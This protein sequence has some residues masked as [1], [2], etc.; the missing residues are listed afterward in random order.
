METPGVSLFPAS[1]ARVCTR[2]VPGTQT[3][4]GR[5]ERPAKTGPGKNTEPSRNEGCDRTKAGALMKR[6]RHYAS[7]R[8]G[9]S[10]LFSPSSP[11]PSQASSRKRPVS[12]LAHQHST[13]CGY[14]SGPQSQRP[15]SQGSAL[16][17]VSPRSVDTRFKTVRI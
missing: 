6:A 13:K 16:L 8:D 17:L 1:E 14:R 2:S 4:S 7:W 11:S 12:L 3:S 10:A 9:S 5:A 15:R